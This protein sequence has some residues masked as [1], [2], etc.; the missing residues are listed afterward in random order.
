MFCADFES[1]ADPGA[2]FSG[3]TKHGSATG[4]VDMGTFVAS[5]PGNATASSAFAPFWDTMDPAGEIEIDLR[6]RADTLPAILTIAVASYQQ[7]QYAA[8]LQLAMGNLYIVEQ[9]AGIIDSPWFVEHLPMG[10]WHDYALV[11]SP[12]RRTL[13]AKVDGKLS[14]FPVGANQ[15][16]TL[17]GKKT[18]SIGIADSSAITP[19]TKVSFDD[20]AIF[21]RGP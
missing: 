12:N 19:A 14:S 15:K 11:V 1:S 13:E 17:A 20:V 8:A 16:F 9:R 10:E 4:E 5:V 2:G 7:D 6:F 21:S 18:I 3:V